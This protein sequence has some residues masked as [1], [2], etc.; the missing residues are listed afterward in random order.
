MATNSG[1]LPPPG[2]TYANYFM[3]YS[4]DQSKTKKGDTI[5]EQGHAAVFADINV[6]IYV[7]R[8]KFLGANYGLM[9]GL[10]FSNSSISSVTLGAIAAA[11]RRRL[12]R[13][14][15][16]AGSVGLAIEAC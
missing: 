12:C 8:L 13:L 6:F 5:F 16:S 1:V 14:F 9:A 11:A 7:T 3:H 4:F 10:P 15:L 2:L